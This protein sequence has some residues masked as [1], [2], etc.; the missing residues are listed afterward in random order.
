[1]LAR[2][3]APRGFT[4][5]E[6]LVVISVIA[7]LI[8]IL[9]PSLSKARR[10][11]RT[12]VC[13]TQLGQVGVAMQLYAD[14]NRGYVPQV[15]GGPIAWGE[16]RG[17]LW[18]L[19]VGSRV[20]LDT[21][22]APRVLV[23]PESRPRGAVSYALNAVLFG[24]VDPAYLDPDGSGEEEPPEHALFVPPLRLSVIR[25]P[26]RLVG[27]YDVRVE[28]LARVW[29]TQVDKDEADMSDQFTATGMLGT[30]R[31][32]PAGFMW[33]LSLDEPPVEAETPHADAHNILFADVH[34]ATHRA[35]DPA[36]MTRLA[37][38]EPNDSQL[39]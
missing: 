18:K 38:L 21:N 2:R 39:H 1:V 33:Q 35:W 20:M 32:N 3:R 10:R 9:V 13:L 14:R 34:V 27:L 28:S 24:Y 4:L 22:E 6:L 25:E 19:M 5:I 17:A 26:S 30:A 36:I 23:C 29:H 8:G 7:L 12:T 31:P 16:E 11:A 37:G 15:Y